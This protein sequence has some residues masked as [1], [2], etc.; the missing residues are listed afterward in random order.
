MN[1]PSWWQWVASYFIEVPVEELSSPTNP[2][3]Q[4][5]LSRG[6]YQLTT[7]NSIYSFEDLYF[8]YRQAFQRIELPHDGANVLI[9]GLGLASVPF[10]LEKIF[11]KTYNYVA[12]EIDESV[13]YLAS[14]YMLGRLRSPI[15]TICADAVHFVQQ[16]ER[17]FDLIIVD[18]FL[19]DVIPKGFEQ[20]PI[21]KM[22]RDSLE[23][24]GLVLY[25]R[26]YRTST[27]KQRT[28]LF[29]QEVFKPVF[30]ESSFLNV[31]GNWILVGGR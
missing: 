12:V 2:V 22:L 20:T 31:M 10:M 9:L 23:K 14:K 16:N 28:E 4:V 8:N 13:I 25:N 18:L 17:L 3:L 27:D 15:E 5:S 11:A 29:Y 21:N 24:D 1:C 26:L 6:R 7:E 19:D 30:R